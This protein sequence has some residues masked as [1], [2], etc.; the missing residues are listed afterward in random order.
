[1]CVR[2]GDEEDIGCSV[3]KLRSSTSLSP[4]LNIFVQVCKRRK[5]L[6]ACRSACREEAAY[7]AVSDHTLIAVHKVK[8]Q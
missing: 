2:E 5:R 6:C 4:R 1:M 3:S 7:G 8:I